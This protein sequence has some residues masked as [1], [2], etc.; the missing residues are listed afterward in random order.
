MNAATTASP[1]QEVRRP[2]IPTLDGLLELAPDT[3]LDLYRGA[4]V[5]RIEEIQGDLR[6]RML[7]LALGG[8]IVSDTGRSLASTSWFPWRGKSFTAPA[9]KG[10]RGAGI[11]RVF[12]DRTR[13][14]RFE[15][16]VGKSRAGDFDAVQL[17][18]DNAVNPFFIR[19][20]KDEIRELRPGLFL[21]QAYVATATKAT[22]ALYFG[23]EM[24]LR[25]GS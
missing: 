1:V 13:L 9:A 24:P 12:R 6:G 16:F 15:T 21:G 14:F 23:L 3:L 7:A 8:S 2:R 11:N 25:N 20:I 4:A 17:D 10:A 5:P 22:L 18:Y 19:A